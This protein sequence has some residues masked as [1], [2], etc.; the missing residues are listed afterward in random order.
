MLRTINSFD[1]K[2]KRVLLRVDF[3]VPLKD[4]MVADNFRI[5]AALPTLQYCLKQGAAVVLMS[6]LGRP[7]GSVGE[8]LSLVPVGESLAELLEMPIKFSQDC[9]SED[10]QEVSLGLKG[11]EIH[12]LENLRFHDG[13]TAN[14]ADF[15]SRLARHGQVYINDAFGTAHRAHA[16]DVGVTSHFAQKGIGLLMEKELRFLYDVIKHPQRPVVL[17]LGGAK[18]STKLALINRFVDE[19]DHILIGGGMAFTFL[20]SLGQGVGVSLVNEKMVAAAGDI[21][22][23]S[24]RVVD[25][26]LP[27]DVV[28]APSP[29]APEEREVYPADQIPGDQMGLDIG[30]GTVQDY[31]EVIRNARTVVW[32][33]PMGVFEV[34]GFAAG[35]RAIA[36]VL[37]QVTPQ[38]VITVVGGGDSAAAIHSYGLVESVSHVSTGGGASLKLLS[39]E[40]L[41]ALAAL[42][43]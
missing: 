34:T 29:A 12:L 36:Q 25:L 42:E 7:Q 2:N 10:S 39:G 3:N 9:I 14:A 32:N 40:T 15:S 30:P 21:L 20:K 11:G 1:L 8:D 37:S 38:G 35:T 23:R 28:C 26:R 18:I 41:P 27:R 43:N 5:R 17:V 22:K 19:A 24:K 16:S 33:G 4:G 31:L 13:E 6:H